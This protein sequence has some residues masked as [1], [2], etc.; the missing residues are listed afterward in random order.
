MRCSISLH[1]MRLM[2]YTPYNLNV[3]SKRSIFF[4]LNTAN[5]NSLQHGE[6]KND[7]SI[8]LYF[9]SNQNTARRKQKIKRQ[10]TCA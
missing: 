4:P 2:L 5:R 9:Q 7:S 10:T 8:N 6:G 1:P 3:R